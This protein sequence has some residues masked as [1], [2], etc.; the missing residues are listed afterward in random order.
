MNVELHR[1]AS[2]VEVRQ[3]DL[4]APFDEPEVLGQVDVLVCN[5]PY[6]SSGKVSSMPAEIARFEP[7]LAFDGGPFGVRI[8][9]RLIQEAPR[10]LRPGGWLAFEVGL[11]Q[12]DWVM[13]RL[14]LSA[15]YADI[16]PLSDENGQIRAVLARLAGL[17]GSGN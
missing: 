10:F 11:G 6:V 7:A 9:T 8:L 4:L 13:R 2:R 12:G 15:D 1:L 17:A 3:G 5:P 14:Q 16:R